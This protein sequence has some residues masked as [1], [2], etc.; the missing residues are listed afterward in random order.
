MRQVQTCASHAKILRIVPILA[1]LAFVDDAACGVEPARREPSATAG[2]GSGSEAVIADLKIFLSEKEKELVQLVVERKGKLKE[3]EPLA[4]KVEAQKENENLGW[5]E[6]RTVEKNLAR[7]R[8][9]FEDI[10]RV[11]AREDEVREEA[12]ACAAAIVA[13]L[14]SSLERQLAR[15]HEARRAATLLSDSGRDGKTERRQ[16]IERVMALEKSRK[17][18]Q[19]KMN[20]LMPNIQVPDELPR[21]VPWSKEMIEDQQR[22][23]EANIARFQSERELKIQERRLR[24]SLADA[25]RSEAAAGDSESGRRI[26]AEIREYDRKIEIYKDKLD[27]M[28]VAPGSRSSGG[29]ASRGPVSGK[30]EV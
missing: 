9:R 4:A 18:F 12:F 5:F 24:R 1:V 30:V 13:E 19:R 29:G 27:R 2:V 8:T 10:E 20:T 28:P 17:L 3:A 25:L 6:K 21:D 11:S 23:Y 22:A 15:L 14:E 26:D 16:Q 7:L